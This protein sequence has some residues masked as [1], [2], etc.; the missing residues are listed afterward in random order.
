MGTK[1]ILQVLKMFQVF[2]PV[3]VQVQCKSF[4]LKPYNRFFLVSVQV[5]DQASVNTP[6]HSE[7]TPVQHASTSLECPPYSKSPKP[8]NLDVVACQSWAAV[9]LFT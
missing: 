9:S 1:P 6:L 4:L 7:A 8:L 5:P 3:P 2:F